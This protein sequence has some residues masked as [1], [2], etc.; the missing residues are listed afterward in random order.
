MITDIT[1]NAIEYVCLNMR[2]ADKREILA[3]QDSDNLLLLASFAHAGISNRGRGKVA[4]VGGKPAAVAAFTEEWPGVWYV[5]MF[6]TADFKAAA[7]PLL[8]W[9]KREASE[10]LSVCN[11][12]RLHCDSMAD[13]TEAHRMIQAMGG[14]KECTLRKLGKGGEDYIRFAWFNGEND[15]VLRA[16]YVRPAET[17]GG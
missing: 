16:G 2:E 3:M 13:H 11:G 7:I 6:G 9:V 10:I 8:R 14:V 12:H 1:Y 17:I 5:W 15:A 4:W